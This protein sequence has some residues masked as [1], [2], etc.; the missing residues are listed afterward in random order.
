MNYDKQ[1]MLCNAYATVCDELQ[2]LDKLDDERFD[3]RIKDRILALESVA[4][5]LHDLAVEEME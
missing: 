1:D 3:I 2:V 4:I 5:L